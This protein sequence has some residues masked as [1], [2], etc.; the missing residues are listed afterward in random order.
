MLAY[1]SL[2]PSRRDNRTRG[3]RAG[4][5]IGHAADY[6]VCLGRAV[7]TTHRPAPKKNYGTP[8][9]RHLSCLSPLS[10]FVVGSQ[11]PACR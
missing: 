5:E 4:V 1:Y 3:R 6:L 8:P 7:Q 11:R 10:V 2:A 9:T